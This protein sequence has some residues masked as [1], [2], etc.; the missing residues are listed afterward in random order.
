[1]DW[2]EFGRMRSGIILRNYPGIYLEGL[3]KP[4]KICQDSRSP[5]RDLNPGTP[6]YEAEMLTLDHN[7]S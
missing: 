3:R 2:K 5:G 4:T 7:I 1:M 6:E